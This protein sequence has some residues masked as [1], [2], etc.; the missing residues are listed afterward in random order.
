MRYKNVCDENFTRDSVN[1]GMGGGKTQNV[2]WRS[3]NIPLP[4]SLEYV[5]INC[6]TNNLDTDNP[7]EIS[8]GL[9]CIALL[10]QKRMK[11]L[12]I[13]VNGLILRDV[14]NTKRRHQTVRSKPIATRQMHK[15]HQCLLPKT[16]IRLDNPRWW[17]QQN[18]LL[19][20]QHPSPRKR[21]QKTGTIN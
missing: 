13:V 2:L 3:K 20:R 16:R 14:I 17:T 1:C 21:K 5:V 9:I 15:L 6:S 7:D 12:Q 8:D 19:Q 4:Q 18:F 10:F 11:H